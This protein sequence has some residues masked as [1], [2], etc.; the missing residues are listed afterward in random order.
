M[1]TT[2]AAL[3][4]VAALLPRTSTAASVS[5]LS[6]GSQFTCAVLSDSAVQCA[7]LNEYGNL[8]NGNTDSE[9]T[10]QVVTGLKAS[11]V[12]AGMTHACAV[13]LNG[14]VACWGSTSSGETGTN[15]DLYDEYTAT[16]VTV[17]ASSGIP[18]IA[19]LCA[20]MYFT[21]AVGVDGT[22]WGW[23]SNTYGVLG[24]S[25]G[26]YVPTKL[27]G[28]SGEP[29]AEVS[30]GQVHACFLTSTGRV[31]CQ[32]FSSFGQIPS[33]GFG[34]VLSP[35]WAPG[36]TV[37]SIAAGAW[38]TCVVTTAGE[39]LCAGS[40]VYGEA[41]G[42]GGV[43]LSLTAV[44]GFSSGVTSV[45]SG[46]SFNLVTLADGSTKFFG[47]SA[48]GEAGTGTLKNVYA[49][50]VDFAGGASVALA[51]AGATH[52]VYVDAT[53]AAWGVGQASQGELGTGTFD[54]A[55]QDTPAESLFGADDSAPTPAPSQARKG[56][57][58]APTKREKRGRVLRGAAVVH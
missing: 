30:C 32:G 9:D 29:I 31:A 23:G 57:T 17:V 44:T 5:G 55:Q 52:V 34:S 21:L 19:S 15:P 4:L 50:G 26:G 20:G 24:G 6:S 1:T 56:K 35:A 58:P 18:K 13:Q 46:Y 41:G 42:T 10:P 37:Q 40:N 25:G 48:A 3:A 2:A 36:V 43:R 22:V 33:V 12:S 27:G 28:F 39:L 45:L 38:H 49:P 54:A 53:G 7:G 47:Q 8:G 11:S 51:S 16:P 14:A